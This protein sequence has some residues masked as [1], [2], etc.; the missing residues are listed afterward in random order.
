MHSDGDDFSVV[1]RASRSFRAARFRRTIIIIIFL[2]SRLGV[3]HAGLNKKGT[4][5]R[6]RDDETDG[7]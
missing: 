7:S 4:T 6:T 2:S 5:T 3:A 1:F